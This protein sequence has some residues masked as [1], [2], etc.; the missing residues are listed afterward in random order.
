[1]KDE[2]KTEED[3]FFCFQVVLHPAPFDLPNSFGGLTILTAALFAPVFCNL[4]GA[5]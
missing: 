2:L 1:V 3:V 5:C 4:S